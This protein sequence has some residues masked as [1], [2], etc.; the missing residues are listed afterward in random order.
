MIGP[1]F[2]HDQAITGTSILE[3]AFGPIPVMVA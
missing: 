1:P 2:G 3:A